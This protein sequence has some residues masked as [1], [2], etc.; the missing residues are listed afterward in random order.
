MSAD[1]SSHGQRRS[2]PR[3]GRTR[4]LWPKGAGGLGARGRGEPRGG[5]AAPLWSPEL[6][7]RRGAAAEHGGQT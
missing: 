1:V 4:P 7:R 6:P 5:V 3:P 2:R